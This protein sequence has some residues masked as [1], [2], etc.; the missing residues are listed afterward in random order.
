MT[1][2]IWSIA[3]ANC[4]G[5]GEG[6]GFSGTDCADFALEAV[7]LGLA[8]AS[9]TDAEGPDAPICWIAMEDLL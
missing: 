5:E 7:S 2:L 8:R 1:C 3:F 4:C 6:T 9:A